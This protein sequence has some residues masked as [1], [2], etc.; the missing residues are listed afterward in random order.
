M[1]RRIFLVVS[2]CAISLAARSELPPSAYKDQQNKAPE[3]LVIKVRTVKIQET[4]EA[5][6][7]QTDVTVEAEVEKVE[8][9]ATNIAPGTRIS[10]VY[11]TREYTRPVAGPS[12]V[13]ILKEGQVCPA[14][15][16]K[17][18]PNYTPAAGG[19]SFETVR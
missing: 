2:L 13:P 10:I 8:R 15:L 11:T 14:Y 16:S 4:T 19:Y 6:W 7:K 17:S 1:D 3:A 9:S 5:N 12:Q 18:G